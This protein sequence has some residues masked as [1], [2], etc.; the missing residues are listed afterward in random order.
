[1]RRVIRTHT[2]GSECLPTKDQGRSIKNS[3]GQYSRKS[4]SRTE[5][6]E[7]RE[8]D[9]QI[10]PRNKSKKRVGM[11]IQLKLFV[12]NTR[13]GWVALRKWPSVCQ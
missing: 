2:P 4:Y 10:N 9:M 12:I 3:L 6:Q 11:E 1:M 13:D 5:R 8:G 7:H